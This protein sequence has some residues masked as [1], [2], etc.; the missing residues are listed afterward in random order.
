LLDFLRRHSLLTTFLAALSAAAILFSGACDDI[1]QLTGYTMG[2]TYQLQIV[3]MP[4]ALSRE[5]IS[6]AVTTLLMDLDVGKFSTYAA[7]SELSRFNRHPV[8]QAF[9]A[10][11][12]FVAVLT[13]AQEVAAL[14]DGAF[15]VTIGPLVNLWGF[16][17]SF[18]LLAADIPDQQRIDSLMQSVGYGF[19]EID[20]ATA[21]VTKLADVYVD[22]SGIAKG[23]AVD[24]LA[25]YFDGIVVEN[26]FL[27]VG[28]EL[29][30]KGHKPGN[31]SWV[32]AIE[33]PQDIESQVYEIFFSNGAH[34]AVA[35]SGDYR[36]YFEVDGVRYSHEIDPRTGRPVSHNL[37]A[38]YVIDASAATA[39]ALATAYMVL[40]LGAARELAER[41]GQAAYFIFTSDGVGFADYVTDEFS[42][43][44]RTD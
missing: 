16:G 22:L 3:D 24:Q 9:S 11:A 44:L 33:T 34:I 6:A 12:E 19:L 29:K 18:Q 27:G 15:D 5:E 37:A 20:A 31:Q 38:A 30:I 21:S 8:N 43:Y 32:P 23:Y 42:S 13:L 25:S 1:Q 28:G 35:G 36:N 41:T 10:S 4:D 7:D 40:G 14:T 17:P 2:T 26:Y 39:D